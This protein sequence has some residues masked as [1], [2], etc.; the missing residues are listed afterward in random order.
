MSTSASS[1]VMS[2]VGGRNDRNRASRAW[3]DVGQVIGEL[4]DGICT[5]PR[6]V[7]KDGVVARSRCSEK[8]TVRHKVL[9]NATNQ[10]KYVYNSKRTYEVIVGRMNDV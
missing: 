2:V 8:T 4:L 6:L 1:D 3:V 9:Q 5:E 7:S 10:R